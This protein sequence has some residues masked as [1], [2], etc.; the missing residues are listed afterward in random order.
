[1]EIGDKLLGWPWRRCQG[2]P[3]NWGAGGSCDLLRRDWRGR[4]PGKWPRS[5][6]PLRGCRYRQGLCCLTEKETPVPGLSHVP[7][8]RPRSLCWDLLPIAQRSTG[9][10][11][12]RPSQVQL[13]LEAGPACFAALPAR[14]HR[15]AARA[16]V[17]QEVRAGCRVGLQQQAGGVDGTPYGNPPPRARWG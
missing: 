1:M 10:S 3:S 5:H 9:R 16:R 8:C 7:L 12:S 13:G 6:C 4:S 17:G 15:C 14:R 11:R 2:N